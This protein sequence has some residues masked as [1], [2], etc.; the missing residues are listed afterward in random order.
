MPPGSDHPDISVHALMDTTSEA[1][2]R[3][4]EEK[5]TQVLN[6]RDMDEYAQARRNSGISKPSIFSGLSKR[7][8][9]SML[10]LFPSDMMHLGGLLLPDL[11]MGLF[12][13]T[14]EAGPGDD[15]STWAWAV[16]M[17]EG[18]W[19]S[20]RAL[21]ASYKKYLS[22]SIERPPRDPAKKINSGYKAKEFLTYVYGMLP[23]LLY[24]VLPKPFYSNFCDLVWGIRI[25]TQRRIT[26]DELQSAHTALVNF[27][28]DFEKI[29]VERMGSRIH[30][31]CQCL[32]NLIHLSPETIRTGPQSLLGQ[33]VMERT[34][35][36]LGE[37]IKQPSN[38]YKNLSESGLR[39]AQVNSIIAML[40]LKPTPPPPH[41]ATEYADGCLLLNPTIH[42]KSLA[43]VR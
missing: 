4:Y 30:F 40:D 23:A 13:G 17:D 38:P 29:Y 43:R 5:L 1:W 16:L 27:V 34:I 18:V 35:G 24:S 12:R 2:V 19:K 42:A 31:V 26:K 25:I 6:S 37:E 32:H 14:I 10:G 8:H 22:S 11:M 41:G 39:Q 9:L 15:K 36:N 20:H 28:V 33:W 7:S 21:V 3:D